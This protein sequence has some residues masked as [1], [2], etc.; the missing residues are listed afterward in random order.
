MNI[1]DP[2]G[3]PL[4]VL[5]LA[6]QVNGSSVVKRSPRLALGSSQANR[7]K[8]T[9]AMSSDTERNTVKL[10]SKVKNVWKAIG[11]SANYPETPKG[12]P[13]GSNEGRNHSWP[14]NLRIPRASLGDLNSNYRVQKPLNHRGRPGGGLVIVVVLALCCSTFASAQTPQRTITQD[15]GLDQHLDEQIDLSLTFTDEQGRRVP[16]REYFDRKPVILSCVYYRCPMLCTEVLTGL[17]KSSNAM[18]LQLGSDYEILSVSIDPKETT[19]LAADKKHTYVQ[20]Y[21]RPGGVQGWHFLTGDQAAITALTRSV[22]FR[23]RYD[24]ASDQFA[25]A[26]GI[27]VLTPGGKISR[28]FYGIDYPPRDLHLSLVESSQNRIGSLVDQVLLLCF[29]YDP[30]TGR[31]GLVISNVLR[32]ASLVT[33]AIMG[34]YL[35]RMYLLERRRSLAGKGVS[36]EW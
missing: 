3:L 36:G 19:T 29:H 22:G 33:L 28:Y 17:L 12:K 8:R 21:R 24:E 9:I 7:H 6:G 25:H 4:G 27:I 18:S 10:F 31:Y 1:Q 20:S 11:I 35:M 5:R 16:L 14:I 34:T 13:W 26:S 32:L 15:V 30:V 23:Y 2:H